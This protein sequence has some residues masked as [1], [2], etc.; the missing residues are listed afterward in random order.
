MKTSAKIREN[1]DRCCVVWIEE[2]GWGEGRTTLRHWLYSLD[3]ETSK[4][5]S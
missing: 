4:D 5:I 1:G 2:H 3:A